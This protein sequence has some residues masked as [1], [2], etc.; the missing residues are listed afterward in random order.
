MPMPLW[1]SGIVILR[2]LP[3]PRHAGSPFDY[4][5]D[6]HRVFTSL[7]DMKDSR[8]LLEAL[9]AI[10]PY[11]IHGSGKSNQPLGL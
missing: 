11:L 2:L 5:A 9:E 4:I 6:H 10:V 7:L 1:L 8:K 3:A